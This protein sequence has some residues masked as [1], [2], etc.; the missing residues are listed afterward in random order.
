MHNRPWVSVSLG[1]KNRDPLP[2][3]ITILWLVAYNSVTDAH[4]CKRKTANIKLASECLSE[5]FFRSQFLS[6][7]FF[8]SYAQ[9]NLVHDIRYCFIT[10]YTMLPTRQIHPL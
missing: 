4:V 7:K 2:A 10:H 1:Y 3:L 6:V 8:T 9:V 5:Y